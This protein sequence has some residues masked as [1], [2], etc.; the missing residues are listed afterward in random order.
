MRPFRAWGQRVDPRALPLPLRPQKE[1]GFPGVRQ[2]EGHC[3]F[4]EHQMGN[5][6]PDKKADTHV[7]A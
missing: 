3:A 2:V 7:S 4:L 6:S 1:M 5:L